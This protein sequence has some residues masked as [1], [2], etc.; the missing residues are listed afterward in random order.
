MIKNEKQ[1]QVTQGQLDSMRRTLE[2]LKSEKNGLKKHPLFHQAALDSTESLIEELEKQ[3][4]IYN[5]NLIS[6]ENENGCK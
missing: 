6:K 3:I 1:K 5:K 4:D 2:R